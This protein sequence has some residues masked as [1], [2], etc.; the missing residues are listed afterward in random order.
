MPHEVK[1]P[2][3]GMT[4]D[5]GVIVSWLKAAGD[6]VAAGDAL[7]EVETDKATMEVE[8]PVEGFLSG[9][10]ASEGDDVPVGDVIALI[11]ESASDVEAQAAKP[12]PP[13]LA[14]FTTDPS[15]VLL[16][17]ETIYRD[18]KR[19]GWL[20]SGGYGYTF[21]RSIGCGYVRDAE[22][23]VTRDLLLSGRYELEVTTT[24]VPAELFLDPLYDPT[25]SR[26]KS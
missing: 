7:F 22:N 9:L 11:V 12:L 25:M 1:M 19:M 2:Q 10:R 20:S 18:G 3:L 23:G 16:G 6:A 5:S 8:A 26:I 17:R 4:Q 15:V 14:G 21:G 13:L 24:R